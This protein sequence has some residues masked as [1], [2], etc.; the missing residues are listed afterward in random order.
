M[1]SFLAENWDP[2]WIL[3]QEVAPLNGLDEG[4]EPYPELVCPLLLNSDL[5]AIYADNP[6]GKDSWKSA[7]YAF[8]TVRSGLAVGGQND[9]I[10][11][12]LWVRLKTVNLLRLPW[13]ISGWQLSFTPN[14]WHKQI[15]LQAWEYT[16]ELPTTEQQTLEILQ[17][18][19]VNQL[20][21]LNEKIDAVGTIVTE[22]QNGTNN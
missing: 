16:G 17:D 4:Y 11:A 22:I 5:I 7:G 18:D 19:I 9:A 15:D 13:K 14:Y 21:V 1:P 8:Q 12:K 3:S 2:I 6:Q 10:T 20:D